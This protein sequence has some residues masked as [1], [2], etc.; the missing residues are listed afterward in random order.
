MRA[1]TFW[2]SALQLRVAKGLRFMEVQIRT[3]VRFL[4]EY[5]E[6]RSYGVVPTDPNH[7][8]MSGCAAAIESIRVTDQVLLPV[9]VMVMPPGSVGILAAYAC[10]V[11]IKKADEVVDLTS[12][13][14]RQRLEHRDLF[15]SGGPSVWKA[16]R[17]LKQRTQS[18]R[19]ESEPR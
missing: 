17:S 13:R 18:Q 16:R 1:D 3:T 9:S 12:K 2:V 14:D 4:L 19:R 6:R 5:D 11:W 8:I 10:S 7:R 15:W